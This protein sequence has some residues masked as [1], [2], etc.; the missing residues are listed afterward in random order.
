MA[1]NRK[2]TVAYR[3]KRLGLTN[4]AKRRALLSSGAAR[5]V[6]RRHCSSFVVQV[7]T[8]SPAGDRVV[9]SAN[10]FEVAKLFGWQ[11]HG[12]NLPSAYL[13]GFLAAKRAVA[14]KCTSAI[15]DL[16]L[17]SPK[18]G[19]AF[20]AAVK[21]AIDAGLSIPCSEKAFPV[22]ERINGTQISQYAS[23][24]SADKA[25]YQ[26]QFSAYVKQGVDVSKLADHFQTCKEKIVAKWP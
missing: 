16:G 26:R 13:V 22:E 14:Q 18:L 19:S 7:I 15:V 4:Y 5:F 10:S 8:Y 1:K 2:Y 9:A 11:G 24:L 3:R 17:A 23:L 6:V 21:G 20:F 12:G 25:K